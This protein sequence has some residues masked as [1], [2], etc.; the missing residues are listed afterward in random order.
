MFKSFGNM[1][2]S[3]AYALIILFVIFVTGCQDK[4]GSEENATIE[5]NNSLVQVD[6]GMAIFKINKDVATHKTVSYYIKHKKER[7]DMNIKC[8][9]LKEINK[10]TEKECINSAMATQ[11]EKWENSSS[12]IDQEFI[13]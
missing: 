10:K 9:K 7:H 6:G 2:D 5:H 11:K 1:G 4:V 8:N 13:K 3:V 12:F